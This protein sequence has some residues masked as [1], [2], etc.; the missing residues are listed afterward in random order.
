ML[1]KAKVYFIYLFYRQG[2]YLKKERERKMDADE[3][4]FILMD[5]EQWLADNNTGKR[6]DL[7]YADLTRADLKH[8]NLAGA[9]LRCAN[10]NSA[11]LRCA[12]LNSAN[13]ADADLRCANLNRAD[14]TDADLKRVSLDS[15]DL[16]DADLDCADLA[17]ANLTRANLTG[18]IL[19]QA[20][21]RRTI[22]THANLT[23]A[24]LDFSSFPLWCGSFNVKVDKR[25]AAQLAYHFCRLDCDNEKYLKA[26]EALTDLANDFHRVE[27]CGKI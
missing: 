27:E 20:S 18:A 8:A 4:K 6:A 24:D 19:R 14:L 9:D 25:I 16:T 15:A 17:D 5:H 3:L 13:L 7:R 11:D 12:N 2:F 23:R 10:L 22:L 26:K 21:L 1:S